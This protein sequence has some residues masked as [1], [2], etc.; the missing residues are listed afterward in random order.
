MALKRSGSIGYLRASQIIAISP[1]CGSAHRASAS[2]DKR[3]FIDN[4]K[5]PSGQSSM[6][7]VQARLWMCRSVDPE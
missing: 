5:Y 6:Q 2:T 3:L 4:C 1:Y 7:R